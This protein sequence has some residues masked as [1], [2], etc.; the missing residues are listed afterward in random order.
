MM[1][2]GRQ[3]TLGRFLVRKRDE[4][5]SAL[6]A[7]RQYLVD[8]ASL[9]IRPDQ[10]AFHDQ[11]YLG[12]IYSTFEGYLLDLAEEMLACF[13]E[14]MKDSEVKLQD[15]VNSPSDFI[16]EMVQKQTDSLG[17]K[18]FDVITATVMQYF[19]P[20]PFV[21]GAFPVVQELK[22]TRDVY[23]HNRGNWNVIYRDKAGPSARPEPQQGTLPLD[24]AY[25]ENGTNAAIDFIKD[26]HSQGPRQ[27]ERYKRVKAFEQMW[28]VSALE[29]VM[30]FNQAWSVD[31]ALDI[32]RPTDHALGWGWSHSETYLFDFFLAIFNTSH[33]NLTSTIQ[34]AI[35]RWPVET[36]SGQVMLSWMRSPFYF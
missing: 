12:A 11:A 32:A 2:F 13:P 15:Y 20:K 6:S 28:T 16:A 10:R 14:K 24:L 9:P 33:P 30:P 23:V 3:A 25:L 7:A 34:Q 17:Y 27:Y 35:V 5:I 31:L 4:A 21:S 22:A 18:R 36:P 1:T 8:T 19:Q 26:F 29:N